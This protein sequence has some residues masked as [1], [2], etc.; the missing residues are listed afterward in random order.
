M[1]NK[2]LIYQFF[3]F[4]FYY[5]FQKNYKKFRKIIIK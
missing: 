2:K 3:I 4:H 5:Y 1:K